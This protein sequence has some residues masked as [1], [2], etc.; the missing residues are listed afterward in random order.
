MK[1]QFTAWIKAQQGNKTKLAKLVLNMKTQGLQTDEIIIEL[2]SA[3]INN[4]GEILSLSS[5]LK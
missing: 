4:P 5:W 1:T 3:G 2:E